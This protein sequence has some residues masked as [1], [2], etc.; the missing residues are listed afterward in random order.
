MNRYRP[1]FYR[2]LRLFLELP[3]HIVASATGV[4]AGRVAAI[5]T[6]RRE[7]NPTERRLIEGFLRVKFEEVLKT[8]G[9]APD[10]LGRQSK[11]LAEAPRG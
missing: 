3:L 4:S 2:R 9:P 7:A 11:A 8:D 1:N 6:G 5:E 10:W